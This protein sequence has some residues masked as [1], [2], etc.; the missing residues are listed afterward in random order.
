MRSENIPSDA[1][2]SDQT[3]RHSGAGL[4]PHAAKPSQQNLLQTI[5]LLSVVVSDQLGD[6]ANGNGLSLY[7]RVSQVRSKQKSRI[8]CR[9]PGHA[10]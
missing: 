9:L 7:V 10:E 6:L 3:C 4:S 2:N 5:D 8:Q 1:A